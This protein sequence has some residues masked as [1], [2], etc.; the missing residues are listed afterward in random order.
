[1]SAVKN[2]KTI[3]DSVVATVILVGG[4]MLAS[5]GFANASA[6]A[7]VETPTQI[8]QSTQTSLGGGSSENLFSVSSGVGVG[9]IPSNPS[10]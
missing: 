1:M 5:F 3:R 7:P 9:S 10:K 8:V 6:P 2:F 4:I